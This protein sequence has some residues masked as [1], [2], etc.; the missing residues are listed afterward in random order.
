MT[1]TFAHVVLT[2]FNA[3]VGYGSIHL[4][5][6]PNCFSLFETL[7]YPSVCS[8]TVSF[9][10]LGF[11]DTDTLE[12]FR[13]RVAGFDRLTPVFVND[14][15]TDERIAEGVASQLSHGTTHLIATRLDN[16]G[17]SFSP[18]SEVH[19]GDNSGIGPM[20]SSAGPS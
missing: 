18:A 1:T 7:C 15:L 13:C 17:A 11:F 9:R 16:D 10:W 3:Q 2:R 19:V 4:R 5:L 12:P 14:R 6:Q 8:R 20:R